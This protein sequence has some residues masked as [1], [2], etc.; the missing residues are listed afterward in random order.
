ML[1][2]ALAVTKGQ[3]LLRSLLALVAVL[4][5]A[6]AL[7]A[8]GSYYCTDTIS[9]LVVD[10]S[11]V[12]LQLTSGLSGLTNCT[13]DSGT[14]LRLPKTDPNYAAHYAL[15]LA[16]KFTERVLSI[17]TIDSSPNCSVMYVYI[18]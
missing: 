18:Q 17:R 6:P 11:G 12:S 4:S 14:Y 13:A 9:M 1:D 3:G 8:C 15:L 5:S 2:D 10:D 16:A 7:G